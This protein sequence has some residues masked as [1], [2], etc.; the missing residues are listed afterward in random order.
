MDKPPIRPCR[1]CRFEKYFK[2]GSALIAGL[3]L[4]IG[5]VVVY[6]LVGSSSLAFEKFGFG[7]VTSRDWNPVENNYGALPFIWGTFYTSIFALVLALPVSLGIAIFLTELAPPRLRQPIGFMIEL[8]AAIPS[9]I[10]GI[11]GLFVLAP[12][13]Q[14]YIQPPLAKLD[15]LPFFTG[16]PLGLGVMT[17]GI[18]VAVM[19]IPTISSIAREVMYTVPENQ[20]EGG[21]ALGMTRW[22]VV[23]KVIIPYSRTGI[24]GGI[25][26]GFG[27]ALG[28]TM[29]VTMVIGNTPKISLSLF[30]P[31]YTIASAIANEFA[32][33][34]EKIHV[35]ALIELG[36]ILFVISILINSVAK[37]MLWRMNRYM[38]STR[39]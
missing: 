16:Y 6:E 19:I 5:G 3:V 30:D 12:L 22:E 18:I 33:A 13:L 17:A 28:E 10:Y 32:E 29:A 35:S 39:F 37:F 7:F 26:L 2:G 14:T 20:K 25:I 36:L 8:L 31:G 4:L 15:F 21:L 23:S 34:T 38:G 27:R 24:L 11:W 9:L 1:K